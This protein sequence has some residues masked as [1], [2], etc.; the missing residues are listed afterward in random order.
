MSQ[1]VRIVNIGAKR[2]V[3]ISVVINTTFIRLII[4]I[5]ILNFYLKSYTKVNKQDTVGA[6]CTYDYQ[7]R[8]DYYLF[9]GGGA[10]QGC[11]YR[12]K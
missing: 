12:L 10:T 3:Q 9:C 6:A 2:Q 11:M 4:L 5:S 8:N 1:D 7:C